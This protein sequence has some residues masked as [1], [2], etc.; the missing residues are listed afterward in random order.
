MANIYIHTHI[1]LASGIRTNHYNQIPTYIHML[2]PREPYDYLKN[3]P[4]NVI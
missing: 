4:N 2:K 1:Y 3:I